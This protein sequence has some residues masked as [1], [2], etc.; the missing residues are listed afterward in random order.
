MSRIVTW[1]VLLGL[2][3]ALGCGGEPAL[4]TAP[5]TEEQKQQI[6]EEDRRIDA[7]ER[8]G[9]F[10]PVKRHCL[11]RLSLVRPAL[12]DRRSAFI[13]SGPLLRA[14]GFRLDWVGTG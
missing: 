4:N 11:L 10:M 5:L 2:V 12:P 1:L 13:L 8:S 14:P 7:E 3:G 6:R 9:G